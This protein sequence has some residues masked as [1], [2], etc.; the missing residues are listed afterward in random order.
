MTTESGHLE[1]ADAGSLSV[2]DAAESLVDVKV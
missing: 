1:G 2:A